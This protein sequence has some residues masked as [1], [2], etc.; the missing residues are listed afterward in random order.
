MMRCSNVASALREGT[1]AA[2]HLYQNYPEN[3]EH[4]CLWL[5]QQNQCPER[6]CKNDAS[7]AAGDNW[8]P[9]IDSYQ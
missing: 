3:K 8:N 5:F 4:S 9:A 6:S 2:A 7:H 1:H